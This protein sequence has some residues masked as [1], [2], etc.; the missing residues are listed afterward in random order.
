MQMH[1]LPITFEVIHAVADIIRAEDSAKAER[2]GPRPTSVASKAVGVF[3]IEK[4]DEDEVVIPIRQTTDHDYQ[5]DHR[6]IGKPVPNASM[7]KATDGS[8][9]MIVDDTFMEWSKAEEAPWKQDIIDGILHHES[10]HYL[11]G[12]IQADPR[13]K[14]MLDRIDE[15][16]L[17]TANDPIPVIAEALLRGG[18][19]TMELEADVHAMNTID[20]PMKIVALHS[21]LASTSDTLGIRMEH[22]NRVDRLIEVLED[23]EWDDAHVAYDSTV[24]IHFIDPD[25]DL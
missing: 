12:H 24:D 21:Y 2:T 13:P 23:K 4:P 20:D 6:T 25:D 11:A 15:E 14:L 17:R 22:S 8:F 7:I 19:Y 18:V 1:G 9:F 5:A 16:A 10:G 3:I